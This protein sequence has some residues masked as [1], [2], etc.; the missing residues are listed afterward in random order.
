MIRMDDVSR[1]SQPNG[2]RS[3]NHSFEGL[4]IEEHS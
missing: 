1:P 4:S 2:E 3:E